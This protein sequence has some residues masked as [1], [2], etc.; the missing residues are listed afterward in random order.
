LKT[1]RIGKLL[2]NIQDDTKYSEDYNTGLIGENIIVSSYKQMPLDKL[3]KVRYIINQIIK[4]KKEYRKVND[5]ND[6]KKE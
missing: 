2:K 4:K 1:V 6:N 3:E 5:A